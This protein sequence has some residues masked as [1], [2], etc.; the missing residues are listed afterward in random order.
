MRRAR[1]RER[2][3]RQLLSQ[4]PEAVLVLTNGRIRFANQ[5]AATLLGARSPDE[6]TGARYADF[7]VSTAQLPPGAGEQQKLKRRDGNVIDVEAVV[8]G[9]PQAR[10]VV[11]RDLA[12]LVY[13]ENALKRSEDR[14]RLFT[15]SVRDRAI[16]TLDAV[17]YIVHWSE[18]AERITGFSTEDIIGRPFSVLFTDEQTANHEH[19]EMLR[20]AIQR[21]RSEHEGW[22]QR[23]DGSQYYGQTLVTALFDRE[24]R[25]NGFAVMLRDLTSAD[26]DG[27]ARDEEQLRQAQRMEAVGRLASGIAHD[28]NNLLT[29]IHGHAQFLTEDI[30][31]DHPSHADAEE[32]LSSAERAAAL[33]RQLLAFSRGQAVQPQNVDL[34]LI[35]TSMEKLMRRVIT[36]NIELTTVLEPSLWTVRADPGQIEQILV[37]LVVN[38]RDAMSEGGIVTIKTANAELAETYAQKKEEVEP[39]NYV[40]LAVSDTGIGMDEA[41][42]Q[43]IFEPFFTTKDPGKGTGLG[44]STVYSIVK[45][46]GGHVFV[47]SEPGH[48]TTVKI[49]LPSARGFGEPKSKTSTDLAHEGETILVIEDD[50]AVRSLTKRVLEARGYQV[51]LV[52]NGAE[53]IR[54][55]S[56]ERLSFSLVVT[57]M[58]LPDTSG[59]HVMELIKKK[60]PS[61]RILLMSGYTAE[62]VSREHPNVAS[63]HFIEKPFTPEQLAH[64]VRK[65]LDGK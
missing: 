42:Q 41:T 14:L 60:R 6:L 11:L 5:A 43:R 45:Q 37:N 8:H 52:G 29:A 15:E 34:N 57:D 28:F 59:S 44:L 31:P 40:M 32:I 21:G 50:A 26:A 62:D 63:A 30:D 47:Y 10:K 33:T 13:V 16:V 38:A 64:T 35:V 27:A 39:G 9:P 12:R 46:S 65:I 56:D 55:L 18:A 53:A 4:L 17:G 22:K 19:D 54:A 2:K 49:Y 3:Y 58:V 51:M 24:Q 48:G 23:A 1:S 36:E 61:C 25:V 20:I 7:V